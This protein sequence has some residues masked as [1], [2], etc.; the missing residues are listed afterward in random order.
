L[1]DN[2]WMEGG[3]PVASRVRPR[4]PAQQ[5][6]RHHVGC[7]VWIRLLLV[8]RP[9]AYA[10]HTQPIADPCIIRVAY[11]SGRDHEPTSHFGPLTPD[12]MYPPVRRIGKVHC[13]SSRQRDIPKTRGPADL[14]PY[15]HAGKLKKRTLPLHPPWLRARQCVSGIFLSSWLGSSALSCPLQRACDS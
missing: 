8:S 11:L 15:T 13:P 4:P 9:A 14:S 3:W 5:Q 1:Q 7:P 6:R 2:Q 12:G 10:V